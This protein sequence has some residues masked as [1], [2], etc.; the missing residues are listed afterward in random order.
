MTSDLSI[1]NKKYYCCNKIGYLSKNDYIDVG[2][3][4]IQKNLSNLIIECADG[5]RIDLNKIRDND[6]LSQIYNIIHNRISK[7]EK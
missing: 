2:N 1:N 4:L 3:V 6:I 7:L 5:C